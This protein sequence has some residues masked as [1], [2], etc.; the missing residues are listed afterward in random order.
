MNPLFEVK[1]LIETNLE[2]SIV[3]VGDLTGTMDHLDIIVASD[4]FIGKSL[5]DQHQVIMDI[6]KE[7]L[8]EKVHAV[9][10]KTMTLEKYKTKYSN[11]GE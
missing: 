2:N 11:Q 10:I 5:I 4:T 9:K 1:N 7:S 8:K 6:L 3:H